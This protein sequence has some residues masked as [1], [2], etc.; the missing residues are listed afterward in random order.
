M[1]SYG[2]LSDME[3][4]SRLNSSDNRAFTEI[5]DRY[6]KQMLQIAW[7]HTQRSDIAKDIVHDVFMS[8]WERKHNFNADCIAAYLATSIKFQCFKFYQKEQRRS[9]LALQN[10]RFEEKVLDEQEWDAAF[11][12]DFIE[13][14]VEEMPPR[15]K[16][17]FRYSR[18]EGLNNREI[19]KKTNITEKGVEKTLGRALKIIRVELKNYGLS[20]TFFMS[21]IS[22]LLK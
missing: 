21:L 9:K 18:N 16:L 5:Y 3:L 10:Y 1:S 12:R 2:N 6:W 11:L 19:A 20:I 15:C 4:M 8:L 7:N 17:I 14:I 22:A 13:G